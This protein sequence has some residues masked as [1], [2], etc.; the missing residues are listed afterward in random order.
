MKVSAIHFEDYLKCPTKCFLRSQGEAGL[1]NSYAGW[2]RSQNELYRTNG[3][4]RRTD[5]VNSTE[6][7][8]DP[9]IG[10]INRA[11][12]RLAIDLT[13]AGEHLE[14]TIHSVERILSERRG[15]SAQLIP[16]R[17]VFANRLN[18]DDKLVLA[19]DALTLSEATGAKVNVGKIVHGDDHVTSKVNTAALAGKLGKLISEVTMLVSTKSPPDLILNRHCAECEFQSRCRQKAIEKD[20]LSLLSNMTAKERK[21]LHSKGIFTVTQLSYTFRP[22]RRPRRLRNKRE[23]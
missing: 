10:N 13:V 23:K 9:P 12:W 20:D 19:F 18:R 2:V 7:A 15:A 21:K 6:C 5:K 16:T 1:E 4:K 22:R 14:S 8:I 17:F 3:I 11:A